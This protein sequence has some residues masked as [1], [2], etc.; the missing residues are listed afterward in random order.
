MKVLPEVEFCGLKLSR[1]LIGAN[2]FGGYSHQTEERDTAMR[3]YYTPDRIVE[4]LRLAEEEGITGMVANN[5]TPHVLEAVER[6]HREGGRLLWFAQ[7]NCMHKPDMEVAIDE[8][9]EIG[10]KA[11]YF[12]GALIDDAYAHRD[13]AKVR[14]WFSY[15][16]AKGLPAGAAGHDPRAHLW[17]N[18]LGIADFHCVCF[19][20]CG[21]LHSGKGDKFSLR[22]VFPASEAV[23]AIEKPCVAYKVL[24]AGRIDPRLGLEYAYES[25]KPGDVVNLGMFRG[26]CDAMV[27]QNAALVR[28]ILA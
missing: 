2:P 27:A 10:A 25:I 1:L 26:D 7:L 24:G 11:V 17:L 18:E 6:Y 22:D 3:T 14:R 16:Q 12:H 21:S 9:A 8:A 20:N 4:T 13:E 15:A 23:R 19:F 28:S 5:E